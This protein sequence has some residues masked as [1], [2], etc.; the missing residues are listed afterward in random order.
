MNEVQDPAVPLRI[1]FARGVAPSK[2][3]NRWKAAHPE[4]PL[5]LVPLLPSGALPR[6]EEAVD[7]ILERTLPSS[8]PSGTDDTADAEATRHTVRLYTEAV[9]LVVPVDHELAERSSVDI[10]DLALVTLLAHPD[11]AA[12]WPDSEPWADPSYA[13]KHVKG[14]LDL[15]ASGLGAILLPLPL[16]RHLGQKREH[17]VLPVVGDLPGTTIWASWDVIRDGADVQAFIGVLRGRTARSSRPDAESPDADGSDPAARAPRE[18]P[19]TPAKQTQKK[20]PKPGSRGAQLAAAKE[21]A[22]RRKA[23]K[24]KEKRRKR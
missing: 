5:E 7:V 11:H 20:G 18:K 14:A 19:R 6:D 1:G 21:K 4:R 17:A 2:W 24:R 12:E 8:R 23:E 22:E 3:A 9:A 16:A 15:V 13:P 10:E